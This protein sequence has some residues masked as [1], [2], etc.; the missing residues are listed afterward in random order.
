[1][2]NEPKRPEPE[3]MPPVPVK[4]PERTPPEIPPD[5]DTPERQSPTRAAN[6]DTGV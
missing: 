6:S 3:I 4:E 5:K 1:M 2:D